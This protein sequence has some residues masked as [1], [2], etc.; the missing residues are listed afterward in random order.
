VADPL[1]TQAQVAE[2]LGVGTETLATWRGT[3]R[4]PRFIRWGRKHSPIRYRHEAVQAWIAAHEHT[5]ETEASRA[6]C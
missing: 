6:E 3:G 2:L 4:G 1:L 5:S